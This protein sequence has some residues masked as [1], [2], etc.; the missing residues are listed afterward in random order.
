M[1]S[2]NEVVA[3]EDVGSD[4][5]QRKVLSALLARNEPGAARVAL[6]S[7][8]AVGSDYEA[9]KILDQAVP[10]ARRDAAVQAAWFEVLGGV[11]SDYEQ[12]QALEALIGNGD[13]DAP[14]A[15]AVP[16]E[17]RQARLPDWQKSRESPSAPKKTCRRWG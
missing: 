9:R 17:S 12:R 10:M 6:E 14:L 11:G 4:Y 13:V 3:L 7:A 1:H 5:E 16:A 2:P 8:Q 15:R